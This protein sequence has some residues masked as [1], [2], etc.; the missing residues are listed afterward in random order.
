[1]RRSK[2]CSI[3]GW[4]LVLAHVCLYCKPFFSLGDRSE[5][6]AYNQKI[7][8]PVKSHLC[9]VSIEKENNV[10]I[11][12]FKQRKNFKLKPMKI[13][14]PN[15]HWRSHYKGSLALGMR[16]ISMTSFYIHC[17]VWASTLSLVF[18]YQSPS[19]SFGPFWFSESAAV[20][21]Q[22]TCPVGILVSWWEIVSFCI[23]PD[24][25]HPTFW[26]RKL[27]SRKFTT[28]NKRKGRKGR[29]EEITCSWC[30]WSRR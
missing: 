15:V 13:N 23:P 25:K 1:M 20:W 4:R 6:V 26:W 2:F 10:N 27:W 28:R 7:K 16:F 14:I 24:P 5:S 12:G 8:K 30:S 21:H 18:V 3:P 22:V 11:S 19:L 17:K 9:V 29:T